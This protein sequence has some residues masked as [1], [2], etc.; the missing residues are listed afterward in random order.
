LGKKFQM[1]TTLEV[2]KYL[3][4]QLVKMSQNDFQQ[5]S[6]LKTNFQTQIT[7]ASQARRKRSP[8]FTA[9]MPTLCTCNSCFTG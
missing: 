3:S 6:F 7:R 8:E 5:K 4:D 9:A 1:L 2:K